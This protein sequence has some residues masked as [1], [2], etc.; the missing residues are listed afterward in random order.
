MGL[1]TPQQPEERSREKSRGGSRT[2]ATSS[3]QGPRH[4]ARRDGA[5]VSANKSPTTEGCKRCRENPRSI[6]IACIQRRRRAMQLRE[7]DGLSVEQIATRMRLTVPR[8]ERLLEEE[9]QHRDLQQYI[10]DSIPA[11]VLQDLIRRRQLEDPALTSQEIAERAGYASRL[12]LLRAVGLEP[13]AR[14][15]RGGKVYPPKLEATVD[16]AVASKIVRA[17]G[18]APREI[19]GL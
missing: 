8:V 2:S 12:A 16:V 5:K 17:L 9:T 1:S 18:F 6:C 3:Q 11:A 13:T 15:I 19:P 7:R 10:C 4:R 14:R